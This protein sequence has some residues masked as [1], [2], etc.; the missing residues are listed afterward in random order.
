MKIG[1]INV[2]Y[3]KTKTGELKKYLKQ[4]ITGI[5]LAA[6]VICC[7]I[8]VEKSGLHDKEAAAVCPYI[9]GEQINLALLNP[10]SASDILNEN[11]DKGIGPKEILEESK[12]DT[13]KNDIAENLI[14]A[15]VVRTNPDTFPVTDHKPIE[16]THD[17][18]AG[19]PADEGVSNPD[20]TDTKPEPI[21][22]FSYSGS[23]RMDYCVGS[24]VNIED[25]SFFWM[26]EQIRKEDCEIGE[27]DTDKPGEKSVTITYNGESIEIPYGVVEYKAV[28][29]SDVNSDQA[30]SISSNWAIPLWNYQIV[31]ESF[32]IPLKLGKEFTGWYTDPECQIPFT[33]A[34]PGM[35]ETRIYAGWKD[36]NNFISDDAGYLTDFIG[37]P[38][39][40]TD[41]VLRV[42]VHKSCVGISK[43]VF[44]ELGDFII[45]A[46]IPANILYI[47][48][49]VFD[50]LPYLMYI[51]VAAD[52]PNY[53]SIGGAV[54]TKDGSEL[55]AEPKGW[56]IF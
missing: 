7:F 21:I 27:L 45:E 8:V 19:N 42:P 52:N 18:P 22:T 48:S 40:F 15:N 12:T 33:A 4:G 50:C 6:C 5:L 9:P 39:V 31:E 29:Y 2:I 46:Y 56:Y 54:Y 35:Y 26:G 1:S 41:G 55:I 44:S 14:P 47:E 25:L 13:A 17:I 28:Y 34:L 49:G 37:D 36:F 23:L 32:E 30:G 3:I 11:L 38:S 43:T 20:H 24:E 10:K 53:C 51:E 16:N